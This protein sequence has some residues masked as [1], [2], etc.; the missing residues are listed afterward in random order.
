M[1]STCAAAVTSHASPVSS[2]VDGVA[3]IIFLGQTALSDRFPNR[4]PSKQA[5][6]NHTSQQQSQEQ[7]SSPVAC[8]SKMALPSAFLSCSGPSHQ[9]SM[10]FYQAE[11]IPATV[12]LTCAVVSKMVL[13]SAS[14]TD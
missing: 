4:A 1:S 5:L 13:P 7:S 10:W 8:M 3:A 12:P 11:Y 14:V 9:S 6:S 2:C